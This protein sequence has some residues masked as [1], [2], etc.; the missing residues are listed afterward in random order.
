FCGYGALTNNGV[1]GIERL[2]K[3]CAAGIGVFVRS[4]CGFVKVRAGDNQLDYVTAVD[5]DAVALLLRG[6]PGDNDFA[7][8]SHGAAGISHTLCMVACRCRHDTC[9]F[10]VLAEI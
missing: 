10:L 4:G 1:A 7:L 3:G 5:H 9:G 2:G 6:W 8:D